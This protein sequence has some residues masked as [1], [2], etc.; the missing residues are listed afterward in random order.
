EAVAVASSI[1]DKHL[2]ALTLFTRGVLDL[3]EGRIPEAHERFVAGHR[4]AEGV[5]PAWRISLGLGYLSTTHAMMG[6]AAEAARAAHE[7]LEMAGSHFIYST[8]AK[9]D[10]AVTAA[11]DGRLL[12][13][14][15]WSAV[16]AGE[17]LEQ[18]RTADVSLD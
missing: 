18:G 17:A 9:L 11:M 13:T 4:V 14:R 12:D 3:G 6:N 1:G 15:H 16:A 2:V 8:D 5:G 10:I 7:A